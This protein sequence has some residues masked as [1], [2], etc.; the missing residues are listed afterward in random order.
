MFIV[1]RTNPISLR[2]RGLLNWPSNVRHPFLSNYIKH[3]FQ[4]H[5][6]AE[7]G[8]R[9]S[10]TGIWIN[11]TVFGNVDGKLLEHP[12]IKDPVLE[13]GRV[14][15]E[16][17]LGKAER[18]IAE[19]SGPSSKNVYL[20][21]LFEGLPTTPVP[22]R[23]I[24]EAALQPKDPNATVETYDAVSPLLNRAKSDGTLEAL[25][26]YRNTPIHLQINII[27]NPMLNADVMAQYIASQLKS[28]KNLTRIYKTMLQKLN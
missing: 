3:I 23:P 26:I 12:K 1:G 24:G 14:K 13:F 18:R 7:P 28:G 8:I 10:T 5:I 20:K 25:Q 6:V 16:R 22:K 21:N 27:K 9:A 17:A 19:I 2:L 11:V 4:Q 15:I